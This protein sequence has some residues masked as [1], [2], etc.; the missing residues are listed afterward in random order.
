[1]TDPS[2]KV[3]FTLDGSRC[4]SGWFGSALAAR[5]WA[6]NHTEIFDDDYSLVGA[7]GGAA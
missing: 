5:E 1:M 6:E 4:E 7:N 2:V 3:Q